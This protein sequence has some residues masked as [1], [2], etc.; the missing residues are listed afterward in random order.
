[1]CVCVCVCVSEHTRT[2]IEGHYAKFG[3]VGYSRKMFEKHYS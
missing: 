3:I 1:M 2:S